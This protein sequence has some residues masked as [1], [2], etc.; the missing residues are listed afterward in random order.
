MNR[1]FFFLAVLFAF[2]SAIRVPYLPEFQLLLIIITTL[3]YGKVN[4]N[5]MFLIVTV[6][7]THHYVI[8]DFLYRLIKM[9]KL[10]E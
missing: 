4:K 1:K 7:C 5:I 8:P 6:F 2:L 3:L 9:I 10:E